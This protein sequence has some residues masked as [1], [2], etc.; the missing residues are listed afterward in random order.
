MGR[1]QG[2]GGARSVLLGRRKPSD[3]G[4][5]FFLDETEE[6]GERIERYIDAEGNRAI[7]PYSQRENWVEK[8]T[9]ET[10]RMYVYEFYPAPG[11]EF[12]DSDV[13]TKEKNFFERGVTLGDEETKKNGVRHSI[14]DEPAA[15]RTAGGNTTEEIWYREGVVHRENGPAQKNYSDGGVL[16]SEEWIQ[17][18][19]LHRIGAPAMTDYNAKGDVISEMFYIEGKNY[20]PDGPWFK[21]WHPESPEVVKEVKF[22]RPI[23]SEGENIYVGGGENGEPAYAKYSDE[24]KCL[25]EYWFNIES[26]ELSEK[27][28][29]HKEKF[30]SNTEDT[31]SRRTFHASG[32]KSLEEYRVDGELHRTDG[33]AI[34]HY[35]VRGE[36]IKEEFWIEGEPCRIP[37][38]HR[39]AVFALKKRRKALTGQ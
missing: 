21:S 26:D 10:Y 32:E 7:R 23:K 5:K 20:N 1:G 11:S 15:K 24:G 8:S 37:E 25:E 13:I 29:G 35:N 18:D 28:N 2:I 14:N 16:T 33:P 36:V 27:L 31:V 3:D 19:E 34:I 22:T 30:H 17:N 9:G 6:G 4:P 38:D 39:Q 12:K